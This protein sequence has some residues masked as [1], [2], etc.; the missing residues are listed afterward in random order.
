MKCGDSAGLLIA[1]A[2]MRVRAMRAGDLGS[3]AELHAQVF[4]PGR[5]A[6]TAYRVREGAPLLSP[7]CQIAVADCNIIGAANMTGIRIGACSGHWLLGPL[8][9]VRQAANRG[10]GQQLIGAAVNS[11]R[12][13]GTPHGIVFLIGDLSYYMRADFQRVPPGRVRLPGPVDPLRLLAE[14]AGRPIEAIPDGIV[15]PDAEKYI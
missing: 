1:D 8:F 6:R 15:T 3:I 14:T 5:F 12:R 4:G 13:S 9:V 10:I 7:H 11:V 2:A